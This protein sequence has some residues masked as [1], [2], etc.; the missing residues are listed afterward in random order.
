MAKSLGDQAAIKAGAT[1]YFLMT[2]VAIN[3]TSS[4]NSIVTSGASGKVRTRFESEQVTQYQFDIAL[5]AGDTATE[6]AF[7]IGTNFTT[8]EGYPEGP[9]SGKIK[10]PSTDCDIVAVNRT[11]QPGQAGILSVTAESNVAV[12][13]A[14]IA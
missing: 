1:T 5:D 4:S 14:A 9:A 10:Y 11:G 3:N 7:A 12:V 6:I 2:T 13:P 8:F